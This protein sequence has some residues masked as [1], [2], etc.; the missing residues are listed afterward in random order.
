[1]K[2]VESSRHFTRHTD[3]ISGVESYILT[4]RIAPM[5]QTLYFTN[6]SMTKDGRF[7]WFH[8][9]FPP[10]DGEEGSIK[11]MAALDFATDELHYYPEVQ[12]NAHVLVDDDTGELYWCSQNCI[13]RRGPLPEDKTALVARIPEEVGRGICWRIATHLTL[14]P[15]KTRLSVD[16]HSGDHVY[17]GTVEIATGIFDIWHKLYGGFTHAQFH[18]SDPELLLFA[19]EFWNE[20]TT[21]IRFV[22][23]EDENGRLRRIYT[24]RRGQEPVGHPPLFREASHE[25]WSADGRRIYYCDY[26]KGTCYIDLQ[27]GQ[28]ALVHPTGFRHSHITRDEKYVTADIFQYYEGEKWYR[29]CAT[30]VNFYNTETCRAMDIVSTNPALYTKENPCTYHIDPH[31]R[32]LAGDRY[33]GYTTTVL[34]QVD[35]A[36]TSTQH[37]IEKTGGSR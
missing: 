32:F 6:P 34:G 3:E 12:S 13:Y 22:I 14:S 33:V 29:G 35:V 23:P 25:Y 36:F 11:S 2:T 26:K 28:R 15:D 37:L 10:V 24:L 8:C 21:G 5:Q 31:P 19:G 27:T 18:P 17:I 20:R 4:T 30:T 1:M 16:I 9:I 7:F